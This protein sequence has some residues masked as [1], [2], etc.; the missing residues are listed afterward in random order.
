MTKNLLPNTVTPG[1]LSGLVIL[2]LCLA[3]LAGLAATAWPP[4]QGGVEE[5]EVVQPVVTPSGQQV[6]TPTAGQ[7]N[8]PA[9]SATSDQTQGKTVPQATARS[10]FR[11]T[12]PADTV[13][14]V[15]PSTALRDAPQ[16]SGGKGVM[17]ATAGNSIPAWST[18]ATRALVGYDPATRPA[19]DTSMPS[20]VPLR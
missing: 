2:F 9:N 3:P 6:P 16:Y 1:L 10:V 14:T 15:T 8:S 12:G 18:N 5:H 17:P 13:P 20:L 4:N 7:V 11:D 19:A